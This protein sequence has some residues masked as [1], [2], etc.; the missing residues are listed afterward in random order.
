MNFINY[1]MCFNYYHHFDQ[2]YSMQSNYICLIVI[3]N[4][5]SNK[6]MKTNISMCNKLLSFSC[7]TW[8]KIDYLVPELK[9]LTLTVK[10]CSNQ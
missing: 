1:K 5:N 3:Y 6:T 2:Q 7:N 8:S 4:N 10:V 9:L